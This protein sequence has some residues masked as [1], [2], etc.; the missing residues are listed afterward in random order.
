MPAIVPP[1]AIERFCAFKW[2]AAGARGAPSRRR[3]KRE[4]G[5]SRTD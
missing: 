4:S 5:R 1:A 2:F 3:P